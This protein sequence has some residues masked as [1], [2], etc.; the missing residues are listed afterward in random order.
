MNI[1]KYLSTIITA[2][3]SIIVLVFSFV[4]S[5]FPESAKPFSLMEKLGIYTLGPICG[6]ENNNFS[7]NDTHEVYIS[8]LKS[9]ATNNTFSIVTSYIILSIVLIV[10]LVIISKAA[11]KTNYKWTAYVC[12]ALLPFVFGDFTNTA[13]FKTFYINSLILVVVLLMCSIFLW[14]YHKN[15]TGIVGII[16]VSILTMIYSCLGSITAITSIVLGIL[17]ARLCII[18]K[19]KLSKILAIV[20]GCCVIIQSICFIFTYKSV[21]YEQNIYNSVFYGVAKYDSVTELGLD[22]ELDNL[23]ET[24]YSENIKAEYNL[25]NKF[26]NKISYT[27]IAKY[28][29]THP[30]NA[31]KIINQQSKLSAM[32]YYDYGTTPYNSLKTRIPTNFPIIIIITIA[33][34]VISIILKK[35]YC[36]IKPVTEFLMGIS[37][38]WLLSLIFGS[39]YYGNCDTAMNMTVYNVLYD[40]VLLTILIGGTRVV[41][42]RQDEKKAEFGITHE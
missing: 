29:I 31:Y 11:S 36:E 17:I 21:D 42:H 3:L 22:P 14:L 15:S 20:M 38:M 37:V 39:L 28:Y 33:F 7:T 27:D 19:N 35:K 32:H 34:V 6:V 4:F 25:S 40:I 2:I 8:L 18:S 26:Y 12:A 13:F 30:V 41:L 16:L 9:F 10:A 5:K 24:Y 1:K 23:K